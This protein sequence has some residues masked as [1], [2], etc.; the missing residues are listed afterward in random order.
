MPKYYPKKQ[1]QIESQYE[2]SAFKNKY[3]LTRRTSEYSTMIYIGGIDYYCL[4]CQIVNNSPIANLAKI[5]YDNRCSLTGRFDRGTDTIAIMQLLLSYIQK[6]YPYVNQITFDDYSYRSCNES[7]QIDLAPLYYVLDMKTW[8]MSKMDA[9]LYDPVEK[10][11]FEHR[12][13]A[14]QTSKS[15]TTWETYDEFVTSRHPL[16]EEDMMELFAFEHTWQDFFQALKARVGL[17]NL[18]VYM[19]P[20]ITN[21]V[22]VFA[23]L[24][25]HSMKFVLA[26]PNPVIPIVEFTIKSYVKGGKYTRKRRTTRKYVDLR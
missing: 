14:F 5:M 25:F 9:T 15:E 7:H 23:K 4:E 8:Y 2:L 3:L 10:Q 18:C 22:K 19:S 17:P 21:F 6:M 11:L 1:S 26:V 20:W 16:P 13:R 24:Q 12:T